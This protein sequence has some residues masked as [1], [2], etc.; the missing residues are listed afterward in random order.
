MDYRKS[1]ID[2]FKLVKVPTMVIQN[3]N[4]PVAH[5]E[6]V[7]GCYDNIKVEKELVW[8]N[9]EKRSRIAG[10]DYFTEHP[11]QMIQWYDAHMK[12]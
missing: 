3:E 6:Y 10:Y 11:E 5:M 2:N 8:I 1:P 9:S 4:D 7:K 12:T